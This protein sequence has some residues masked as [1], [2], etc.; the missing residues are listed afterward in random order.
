MFIFSRLNGALRTGKCKPLAKNFCKDKGGYD[1]V[2]AVN[3][4]DSAKDWNNEGGQ[5]AIGT[6]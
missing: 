6:A 5:F 2:S 3:V 1:E 4:W